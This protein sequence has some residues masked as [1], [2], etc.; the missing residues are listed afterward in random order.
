MEVSSFKINC[1]K[2]SENDELTFQVIYQNTKDDCSKFD[3]VKD[4][5]AECSINAIYVLNNDISNQPLKLKY[6][7]QFSQKK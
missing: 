1:K 4:V 3:E 7:L 2:L 6:P 5:V